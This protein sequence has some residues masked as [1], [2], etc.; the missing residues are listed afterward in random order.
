MPSHPQKLD[1][2]EA[3]ARLRRTGHEFLRDSVPARYSY[4]FTWLG[5]PIIQY[6]QDIVAIQEVIWK[7]RPDLIVETGIAHGGSLIF[8]ASMLELIGNDGTVVGIDIDFREE[9]RIELE[10][11]PLSRRIQIITGSSTDTAVS[12]EVN[13]L[14]RARENPL[15]ILD[16]NH[17]HEH[18]LNELR[19][20]SPLVRN[21]SYLIVM[22]TGI[23]DLPDDYFRDRPWSRGDNPRTAVEEFLQRNDRFRIDQEIYSKLMISAAQDGYLQC[24]G[25]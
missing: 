9:N 16:S 4:N 22:D 5:R 12:D 18:V 25:D 7:V 2:P 8:H 13:R 3:Q 6:P 15:V 21:G 1:N 23:E 20:Y 10:R 24:I 14:A 11:H 19:L 17:T